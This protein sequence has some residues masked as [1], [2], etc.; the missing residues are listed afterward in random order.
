MKKI[1]RKHSSSSFLPNQVYLEQDDDDE[2]SWQVSYLDILTIV[3]GCLIILL[4]YTKLTEKELI[5]VSSIFQN[6]TENSEYILTP[7]GNIE[8]ELSVLLKLEIN[9]GNL[10]LV[11]D[12]NDLRIRFNSDILYNS[13]EARLLQSAEYLL[14]KVLISVKNLKYKDFNI[15]VE[16]H[17][18]DTPIS[19]KIYPSNW[20]LSTARAANIVKYF[21]E[22]GI[23]AKR[24]KASGYADT[25]PLINYDSLGYSLTSNK[26][27]NRR[28]VL[29]LYYSVDKLLK[30]K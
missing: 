12:L 1:N 20:E 23:D 22:S 13:G 26:E 6:Q 2:N 9:K 25:K 17:T 18:D 3:L 16:G 11:R 5:S 4:S 15:D 7:I 29:R 14:N 30:S 24:L 8:K 19:S 10:E 21:N 27:K 28:I